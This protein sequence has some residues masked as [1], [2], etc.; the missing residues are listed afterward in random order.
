[1]RSP[2]T[3]AR[4]GRGRR[5]PSGRGADRRSPRPARPGPARCDR[6][7]RSNR[8]RRR[9]SN[10]RRR[11]PPT[12]TA[13]PVPAAAQ[14]PSPRIDHLP[15]EIAGRTRG[16][17]RPGLGSPGRD[18]PGAL[19]SLAVEELNELVRAQRPRPLNRARTAWKPSAVRSPRAIPSQSASA[20]SPGMRPVNWQISV[21]NRAPWRRSTSITSTPAPT[22]GASATASSRAATSS[23]SRSSRRNRLIG[24]AGEG[25]APPRR[26]G[27][28]K[29]SAGRS[30]SRP[31]ET[32]PLAH[33]SSSKAA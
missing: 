13:P 11:R 19:S 32:S 22:T 28:P 10:R 7:R 30:V 26:G 31:K 17:L 5:P 15:P 4:A 27:P 12:A 24:V 33:H 6:R 20:T 14:R 18:R 1:M 8:W 21:T 9:R 3:R 16:R 23:H 25:V 29:R 2:G